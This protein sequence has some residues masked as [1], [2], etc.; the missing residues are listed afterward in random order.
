[1]NR[2]IKRFSRTALIVWGIALLA[3]FVLISRQFAVGVL[4]G[5][6]LGLLNMRGLVRGVSKLDVN[7]P[8]PAGLFFGVVVR[9]AVLFTA[10]LL[11]SMTGKVNLLG[12][13][14]GFILIIFVVVAEGAREIRLLVKEDQDQEV[15]DTKVGSGQAED[16]DG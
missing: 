15:S 4:V 2:L 1:M 16:R 6:A 12:L 9:L 11:I 8:R 5:G 14:A 10:I 13:L 7:D 3:A